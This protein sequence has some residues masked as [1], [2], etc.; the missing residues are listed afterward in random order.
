MQDSS[1][2]Y[3][4]DDMKRKLAGFTLL[5]MLL[6]LVIAA[7]LMTM[8]IGYTTQKADQ[9][10]RDRTSMQ[11]QQI[12]NASLA[13]YLANGKWP[14]DM[15]ALATNGYI[16]TTFNNPY[17]YTF[18]L[19]SA[20]TTA[21][22]YVVTTTGTALDAFVVAGTLPLAYV[23]DD[24]T[25]NPDPSYCTGPSVSDCRFVVAGVNVPGQNLNNARSINFAGLYHSGACVPVPSCPGA[26]VAQ[27]FVV[28]ASINGINSDPGTG[29]AQANPLT[30]YTAFA[31]LPAAGGTGPNG[32]TTGSALA[33]SA[34]SGGSI[35]ATDQYWRV[36]LSVVTT[37][38][39]VSAPTSSTWALDLG[40]VAAFTRC[41]P[42]K[43]GGTITEPSG[44]DFTVWSN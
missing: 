39:S 8:F 27:I 2:I 28:P 12:L 14:A 36:C 26:M 37:T 41:V 5:E 32:C 30:G 42:A 33:C 21:P 29:V 24:G 6:V 3:A 34:G 40:T 7:A 16:P 19:S 20:S 25:P 10:R 11:M 18:S 1:I 44:S 13:Y 4:V 35:T 38:G 43:S 15:T 9:L 22:L 23:T 17:G 31:T